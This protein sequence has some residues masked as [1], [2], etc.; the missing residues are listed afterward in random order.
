MLDSFIRLELRR[1]FLEV[2]RRSTLACIMQECTCTG[3]ASEKEKK[4]RRPQVCSLRGLFRSGSD[5]SDCEL[6]SFRCC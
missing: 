1:E 2:L 6:F 3:T 4:E 5:S